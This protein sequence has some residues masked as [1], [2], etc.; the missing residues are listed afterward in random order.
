[1]A[2][3]DIPSLFENL[4]ANFTP[5]SLPVA[6]TTYLF[7][8]SEE[9]HSG[10]WRADGYRWRQCGT[11]S[12]SFGSNV[13]TKKYFHA[14]NGPN[15]WTSEFCRF[16][17][18]DIAHPNAV[19]VQYTGDE[20][21]AAQFPHGN[22][23][24]TTRCYT[25][26]QPHVVH[27]IQTKAA[28]TSETA[29][30]L[31]QQQVLAGPSDVEQQRTAVPRNMEQIRNALKAG[32]S[33][34]R[35][36]RDALFNLHELAYDTGFIHHITTYPDLVVIMYNI[37]TINIFRTVLQSSDVPQQLS[38]DTTFTLGDFYLSIIL[39]RQTEFTSSPVLPL[40]F[41][42][43]ERKT[44]KTHDILWQHMRLVCPELASVR[45]N[46][47]VTTDSEVAI[48][49][50]IHEAFPN[51]P[52]FLCRN[53]VLQDAKRYLSAHGVRT[54][55]EMR[56]YVDCLND[57]FNSDS[58]SAYSKALIPLLSKWSQPF[59]SYYTDNIHKNI[60]EIGSWRSKT[61]GFNEVTT[62]Q[63]ESFNAL[64]K[65]LQEWKEAPVDVMAMTL[66]RLTQYNVAEVIRGRQDAGEYE[67]RPELRTAYSGQIVAVPQSTAP[68]DIVD[69]LRTA[70]SSTSSTSSSSPSATQSDPDIV[71]SVAIDCTVIERAADVIARDAITLNAKLA[72]FIVSGTTEPRVVRLFPK[73]TCSCP[74]AGG[75]YH[76]AAAKKAIGIEEITKRRVINL[77]QLRRN[78]R[79]RPDKTSGRKRPRAA[80]V[81]VLA[82][83]DAD[84]DQLQRLVN[85]ISAGQHPATTT[86][87]EDED[88]INV[89]PT[90][91]SSSAPSANDDSRKRP[92]KPSRRKRPRAADEIDVEPPET[93]AQEDEINV[94]P[95][96]ASSSAPS[97]NDD[98]RC[99]ECGL[100]QPPAKVNRNLVIDW[101]MCDHC[102]FW[103]H[104][105]CIIN[106]LPTRKSMK[107][108]CH[109]CK[110]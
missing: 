55:E 110:H 36:S 109:R 13:V 16:A 97:A 88:E 66:Y 35:L 103:Y 99:V 107:Y 76:I 38:Y 63:S 52:H 18:F 1:M 101:I 85:K 19:V 26:T 69:R 92:D 79:K 90:A 37:E 3:I 70:S 50:A 54:S 78:N 2:Q 57:L 34:S 22:A 30:Q 58:E 80:D 7:A 59:S 74:A 21:V 62:N 14:F 64:L 41:M 93:A 65:R 40:A 83:G 106:Y 81:D 4:P 102:K 29:R 72:T 42:L 96:A 75:C 5:I 67:L 68:E 31:Y 91:A 32:R 53:H 84:D 10:D 28:S 24:T 27:D 60:D 12:V 43:H 73:S 17:F 56:Y 8:W 33:R 47:I 100:E 82:A 71:D 45:P 104:Q 89:E 49:A 39:F 94:E 51:L 6:G 86:P 23:K 108:I 105:C 87:Q 46:V 15:S 98:S 9:S 77:T 20:K 25:R 61:C 95:T 48:T 44:R 11:K